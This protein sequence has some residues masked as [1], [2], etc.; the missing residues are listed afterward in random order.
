MK[1]CLCLMRSFAWNVCSLGWCY[2]YKPS[3][4]G[5]KGVSPENHVLYLKD[6]AAVLCLLQSLCGSPQEGRDC[7]A[8]SVI[9][10]TPL[11]SCKKAAYLLRWSGN[12]FFF[13]L[14]KSTGWRLNLFL[15]AIRVGNESSL[16][17]LGTES[18]NSL[19]PF[20]PKPLL[21]EV[22]VGCF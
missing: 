16:P 2:I 10:A 11:V 1:K 13:F 21:P 18:I 7:S 9:N 12:L 20:L 19:Q 8:T 3:G 17:E 14:W 22:F 4:T 15:F 5:S 6:H